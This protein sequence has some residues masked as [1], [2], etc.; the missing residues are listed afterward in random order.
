MATALF[1]KRPAPSIHPKTRS[2]AS[3]ELQSEIASAIARCCICSKSAAKPLRLVETTRPAH[4]PAPALFVKSRPHLRGPTGGP[5]R[6][7]D[8]PEYGMRLRQFQDRHQ[9]AFDARGVA[10]NERRGS[11]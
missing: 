9:W 5:S 11:K 10:K 7:H 6:A 2:V 3:G 4:A 8:R 1:K